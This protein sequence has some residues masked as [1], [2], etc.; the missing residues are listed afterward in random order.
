MLRVSRHVD[1]SRTSLNTLCEFATF[2]YLELLSLVVVMR[3]DSYDPRR[4]SVS[5]YAPHSLHF[6][7]QHRSLLCSKQCRACRCSTMCDR[8]ST[9]PVTP[10]AGTFSAGKNT[11][12][13]DHQPTHENYRVVNEH[14]SRWYYMCFVYT[15]RRRLL[16]VPMPFEPYWG[17]KPIR[18]PDERSYATRAPAKQPRL[19]TMYILCMRRGLPGQ[20]ELT[21]W[22]RRRMVSIVYHCARR[23]G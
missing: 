22:G 17:N 3:M 15:S 12:V 11:Y 20:S 21:T 23:V 13:C 9:F 16:S 1:C 10:P 14:T 2:H 19:A 6:I 7:K 18:R 8:V 5:T 4:A